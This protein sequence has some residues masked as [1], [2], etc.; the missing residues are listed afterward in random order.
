M[1]YALTVI[2]GELGGDAAEAQYQEV[3]DAI[4]TDQYDVETITV[5]PQG[6]WKRN[7][8]VVDPAKALLWADYVWV[9]GFGPYIE[10]GQLQKV[11]DE[12]R[13]PYNGSDAMLSQICARKSATKDLLEHKGIKTPVGEQYELT[14][15]VVEGLAGDIFTAIPQPC[16]IKSDAWQEGAAVYRVHTKSEI[17]D[18]LI[19]LAEHT[20]CVV[21]EEY[22]GGTP[23][24]VGVIRQMREKPY[25][26]LPPVE[27]ALKEEELFPQEQQES[28]PD[29][30]ALSS[31]GK[32]ERAQVE[33]LAQQIHE[34]LELGDYSRI[35]MVVHPSRGIFV[36]DINTLPG[37][38][39]VST[40][41]YA[42]EE[43]GIEL[44][45]LIDL[46]IKRKL[47]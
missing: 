27:L 8:K 17:T 36:L 32:Q 16:V 33:E 23:V 15:D 6:E 5:S 9:A 29:S 22:I 13:V 45:E 40:M 47:S 28:H 39:G 12:H 18:A 4:D 34:D 25:Y 35:D 38:A 21:A 30:F 42:M 19:A 44:S 43:V 46:C 41:R 2:K 1:K 10:D 37:Y 7:D 11:L 31:L 3:L 14:G 20:S 26:V 24:V